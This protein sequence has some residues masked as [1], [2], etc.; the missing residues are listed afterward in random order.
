MLVIRG[1]ARVADIYVTEFMRMYRHY[2]FWEWAATNW[3]T[4]RTFLNANISRRDRGF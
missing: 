1:D 4:S 3:R 2:V